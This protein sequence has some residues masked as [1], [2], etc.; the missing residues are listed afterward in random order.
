M[1]AE[2]VHVAVRSGDTA[3]AHGNSHLMKR[4]GQ[5]SPE[6]PVAVGAV[7]VGAR[8]A[9][10]DVVQVGE[11]QRIAQEENRGVVAHQ[12]PVARFGIELHGETAN[13]AL[14]IGCAALAGDGRK[15]HEAF[16][17][18]TYF[19]EDRGAGIL[20]NVVRHGERTVSART[21]GMHTPFGD[22]LAVEMRKFFQKPGIL[23]KHR[24]R[25]AG[26]LYVLVI[27]HWTTG[28]RSH[29]FL[30]HNH[31][32]FKWLIIIC[33]CILSIFVSPGNFPAR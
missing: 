22:H 23:Q 28:S 24:T 1:A 18:L 27:G 7:H 6:V 5:R 15:T 19:R 17:F 25:P 8:I 3:I 31:S 2:T 14:C 11:L 10:D 33:T 20:G 4:F 9:L 21:L 29:F 30:F 16:R 12:I 26:R 13:V 32:D